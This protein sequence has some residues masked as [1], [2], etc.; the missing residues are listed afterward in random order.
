[1]TV[2]VRHLTSSLAKDTYTTSINTTQ[3]LTQSLTIEGFDVNEE[4]DNEQL[5]TSHK[6][7]S[8]VTWKYVAHRNQ[9]LHCTL[10]DMRCFLGND[11]SEKIQPSQ[12]HYLELL[13]EDPDSDKTMCI[14]VENLLEQYN[15]KEQDGWVVLYS[16][17]W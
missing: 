15:I 5:L 2:A 7:F 11:D 10:S 9:D 6:S 17:C 13:N 14:I 4:E 3:P 16:R 12:I 1:M 8:H